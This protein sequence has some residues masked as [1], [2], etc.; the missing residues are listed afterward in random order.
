MDGFSHNT[1]WD[2]EHGVDGPLVMVSVFSAWEPVTLEKYFMRCQSSVLEE[3]PEVDG[4]V[5]L[6]RDQCMGI[7]PCD[8]VAKENWDKSSHGQKLA[9]I[10]MTL[11]FCELDS[12]ILEP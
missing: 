7:D 5:I 2:V 1:S 10:L 3:K 9:R 12:C 8:V 6:D 11:L 4:P